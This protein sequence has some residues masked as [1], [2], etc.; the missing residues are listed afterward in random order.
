MERAVEHR[1][2]QLGHAGV[3][4][5]ELLPVRASLT[6]TTRDSS[7]PAG[8]TMLR[9]GSR[10]IARPESLDDRQQRRGVIRR[11]S[12][13]ATRRTRR[14]VRRRDRGDRWRSRRRAARARGPRSPAAARRSG[15]RSVICEPTWMCRPTISSAVAAARRAGQ[16]SR[17]ASM[18]MPNLLVF[19]PVEMCGWLRA[20]MSGLT[21]SATRARVCRSRGEAIDAFELTFGLGIDGLDAQIDRLRQLRRG[22]ADAGEDD[23]RRG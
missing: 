18:A 23:L 21:R 17:A 7:A 16:I 9:P 4:D 22:L 10:T 11:R 12:A 15:S 20:S 5:D 8:A 2:H 13:P 14:R 19:R 3:E 1:A 6:S